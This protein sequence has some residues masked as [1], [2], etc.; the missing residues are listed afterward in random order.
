MEVQADGLNRLCLGPKITLI[1]PN[2]DLI[3]KALELLNVLC[4]FEVRRGQILKIEKVTEDELNKY[5]AEYRSVIQEVR[6]VFNGLHKT[7]ATKQMA[8]EL[9]N[10]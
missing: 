3:D 1:C 7:V 2:T 5:R 4:K 10:K 8:I 9:D 6:K